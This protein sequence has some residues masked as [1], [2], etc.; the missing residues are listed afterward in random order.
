MTFEY[1]PRGVCARK[2]VIEIDETADTV[3]Q[4]QIIGGCHGNGQGIAALVK[5]MKTA[6]VIA[7]LDGINCGGKGTS[8]PAQLAAALRKYKENA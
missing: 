3:K 8:C 1:I 7:R 6:D 4:V 5:G 2:M